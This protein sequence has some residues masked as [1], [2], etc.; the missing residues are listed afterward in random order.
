MKNR[1]PAVFGGLKADFA[2]DLQNS[3]NIR[4]LRTY[5]AE[6]APARGGVERRRSSPW[7]RI[8]S[9]EQDRV[10]GVEC[11]QAELEVQLFR[12]LRGLL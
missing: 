10:G 2:C 8:R 12:N 11:I 7:I 4:L 1:E 9:P 5:G 3:R 6:A